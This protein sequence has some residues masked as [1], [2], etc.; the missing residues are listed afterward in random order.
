MVGEASDHGHA[1]AGMYNQPL[2]LE[3]LVLGGGLSSPPGH[4]THLLRHLPNLRSLVL[5]E[6][7]GGGLPQGLAGATGLTRFDWTVSSKESYSF[8]NWSL[9]RDT[10][11]TNANSSSGTRHLPASLRRLCWR[12][13]H[14]H[15]VISQL[16]VNITHLTALTRLELAHSCG[17]LY[18]AAPLLALPALKEL[19]LR[20]S[21]LQ[22]PS[23]T[24][25]LQLA[26]RLVGLQ[27]QGGA[28]RALGCLTALTV[29]TALGVAEE[30]LQGALP[31][32]VAL[33]RL[34][35]SPRKLYLLSR[36]SVWSD[37]NWF[38]APVAAA[39]GAIVAA[40]Q[41][42]TTSAA[43]A[44]A[45]DGE[46]GVQASQ[47]H[48]QAGRLLSSCAGLRDLA[49][50]H[51]LLGPC[52]VTPSAALALV[53][54]QQVTSLELSQHCASTNTSSS[55]RSSGTVHGSITT[56]SSG[57][58]SSSIWQP[59]AAAVCGLSSLKHLSLPLHWVTSSNDWLGCLSDARVIQVSLK[60]DAHTTV[61]EALL[62]VERLQQACSLSPRQQQ[63]QR[64][65]LHVV[66]EGVPPGSSNAVKHALAAWIAQVGDGSFTWQV[67]V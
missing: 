56:S 7:W 55:R 33:R 53:G 29:L 24:L 12:S 54:L 50:L 36:A 8:A 59:W 63:Q 32:L 52:C 65:Q 42:P 2:P 49:Q 25:L 9:D 66:L 30:Y 14:P 27:L 3:E 13:H 64:Q 39:A 44:A 67:C 21:A 4:T 35:L 5:Q 38:G 6:D 31:R 17:G 10:T 1:A 47:H 61:Q 19:E 18:D 11:D 60:C 43:A 41:P 20:C 45:A 26:P 15:V 58:G 62:A 23:D 37:G 28:C 22:P 48:C 51:L 16:L 34:V 46:G 40:T 57:G